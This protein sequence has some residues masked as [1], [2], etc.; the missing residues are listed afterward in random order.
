MC[1]ATVLPLGTVILRSLNFVSL[2]HP[3]YFREPRNIHRLLGNWT[4]SD[5]AR[6]K[7]WHNSRHKVQT[8]QQG[9]RHN[10]TTAFAN[11]ASM[12][13]GCGTEPRAN[14]RQSPRTWQQA[15]K[16]ETAQSTKASQSLTSSVGRQDR[17]LE[18][19]VLQDMD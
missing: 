10:G 16:S 9:T 19:L 2:Y 17:N 4:A 8:S 7:Q 5:R 12:G 18:F 13:T 15:L 11:D 3:N 1:L 14:A 6:K